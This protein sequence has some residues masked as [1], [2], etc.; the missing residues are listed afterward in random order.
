MVSIYGKK[1]Y[2]MDTGNVVIF[3]L[4]YASVVRWI[5]EKDSKQQFIFG[6]YKKPNNLVVF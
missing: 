4:K 5:P 6:R 2:I 3:A 1:I